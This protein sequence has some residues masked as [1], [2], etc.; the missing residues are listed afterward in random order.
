MKLARARVGPAVVVADVV[1][2]AVVI[3]AVL[4]VIVVVRVVVV[5]VAL[6]VAPSRVGSNNAVAWFVVLLI[7]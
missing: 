4:A 7:R 5:A 1:S 2:A 3:A 6:D